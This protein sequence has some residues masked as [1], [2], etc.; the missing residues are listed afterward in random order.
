MSQGGHQFKVRLTDEMKAFVEGESLRNGNSMNAEILRAL[1]ERMDR[2]A[3][4]SAPKRQSV[5]RR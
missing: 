1:R 2:T 3:Q 5:G 4:R